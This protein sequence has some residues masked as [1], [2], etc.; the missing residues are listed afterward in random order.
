LRAQT[1]LGIGGAAATS[2]DLAADGRTLNV[3][4]NRGDLTDLPAGEGIMMTVTGTAERADV[5]D[6]FIV[7]ATVHVIK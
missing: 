2:T 5:Q 1:L 3:S 6:A 7:G 4:F